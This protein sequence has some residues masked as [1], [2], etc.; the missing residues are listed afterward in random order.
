MHIQDLTWDLPVK[1][2]WINS[3][4]WLFCFQADWLVRNFLPSA[5]LHSYAFYKKTDHNF[6]AKTATKLRRGT[7]SGLNATNGTHCC[8]LLTSISVMFRINFTIFHIH[9][10]QCICTRVIK[11]SFFD[12]INNINS[13]SLS[14]T[15][16]VPNSVQD[17]GIS[18]LAIF[19][20]VRWPDRS[21]SVF[22]VQNSGFQFTNLNVMRAEQLQHEFLSVLVLIFRL[23]VF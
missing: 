19:H 7:S 23:T 5:D 1:P 15:Q 18:A 22:H 14:G 17:D 4:D 21:G 16:N 10:I 2:C 12:C 13:L 6:Q 11:S 20:S 8:L 9:L 3:L